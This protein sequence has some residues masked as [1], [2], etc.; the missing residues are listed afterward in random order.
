MTD[1]LFELQLQEELRQMFE[2]DTQT[3]L[4][5]YISKILQLNPQTWK[6]DIQE[7]YRAIHTIKGGAVTV[8]ADAILYVAIA[9]E[10]LLSDLRYL[11][12]APSLEDGQMV[13]FLTEA[14]ELLTSTLSITSTGEAAKQ[15][16]LPTISRIE[17]LRSIIQKDYIP[18]WNDNKVLHQEFAQQG[19]DLVILELEMGLEGLQEGQPLNPDL[20]N[21]AEQTLAQ[22]RE[23]GKSIQM[24]SGWGQLLQECKTL[25]VN[26]DSQVWLQEWP[27]YFK[28]LKSCAMNSGKIPPLT[29]SE[30]TDSIPVESI[31][32]ISVSDI[33]ETL[34]EEYELEDLNLNS[35]V[36]FED[37]SSALNYLQADQETLFH[38]TISIENVPLLETES[39]L[40][41]EEIN[42]IADNLEESLIN[43]EGL[44]QLTL[45]NTLNNLNLDA[46]VEAVN[47]IEEQDLVSVDPT[48]N[49]LDFNFDEIK[50]LVINL[51]T[52]DLNQ[53]P[54]PENITLS[55]PVSPQPQATQA[56]TTEEESHI[57]IPVSLGR[58]NQI[59]Q[60]LVEVLLSARMASGLY[61]NLASQLIKLFAIA[62]ESV[63]YIT[64]L[65]QIQD[66][67]AVQSDLNNPIKSNGVAVERYR[68]GYTTINRLLEI[69][70]RLSELGAEASKI[71]HSTH[72]SFQSLERNILNLE[73]SIETSRVI[74]FKTVAFR[75]RAIVRDLTNR[76]GKPAQVVVKGEEIELDAGISAKLEPALLHL[77]RNAYDHGLEDPQERLKKGK[78]EKGTITISLERRGNQYL[79]TIADDGGGIDAAKV[80][81]KAKEAHLPLTN[82]ETSSGLLAVLCQPG[83]SSKDEV[84]EISGRGV[85]MDV[86]STQVNSLNGK[87]SLDTVLGKGTSFKIQFPTPRLLVPCVLLHRNDPTGMSQ[88]RVRSFAIPIEN[89]LTSTL[90][91]NLLLKKTDES[92]VHSW[93]VTEENANVP[94]L[95][96][97][98]YWLGRSS[99]YPI[100][101]TAIGVCVGGSNPD[102][103]LWLLADELGEQIELLNL[104][105]P[106]PLVAPVG[107]L[108]MSLQIDGSLIPVIDGATLAESLLTLNTTGSIPETVGGKKVEEVTRLTSQMILVVDDAALMRRR[109]EASLTAYGHSVQTCADG[110]EAWNWLQ[111]NPTPALLITDLE[112]PNMD[113]FTLIGRLRSEG[114]TMPILVISSRL[115]EEWNREAQRLGADGF[116]TKGFSTNELIN[117]VNTLTSQV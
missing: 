6:A 68:Q 48:E 15:E 41:L 29:G 102:E 89:V 70:L 50:N 71:T 115:S 64:R 35:L 117:K 76:Y 38:E 106:D 34:I 28:K 8:G 56:K 69:S 33:E 51:E 86:V 25:L 10:D 91:S 43:L 108:G 110:L 57:Q 90:W 23:I 88:S 58:A 13:Q 45:E 62:S 12:I 31:D 111:Y 105:L 5:S 84:S 79:L 94:A 78:L 95:D 19:F 107:L 83:F 22:L 27:Q 18:E 47:L 114:A 60:H 55:A 4:Q 14:G 2:V 3:Y 37:L 67:Y 11:E 49:G 46:I 1:D 20:I 97:L 36:N 52:S 75:A 26:E 39:I 32:L 101:E 85:G 63:N 73:Q 16:V 9:L 81:K 82:A 104:P 92:A 53:D 77:I 66:D 24:D 30:T 17:E 87:M 72:E 59:S 113:G 40:N 44:D 21:I 74:P 65:R 96:L 54:L 99:Q 42:Q 93:T 98:E 109:I 103:R 100:S 61:N 112:M 7:I 116:L 80:V